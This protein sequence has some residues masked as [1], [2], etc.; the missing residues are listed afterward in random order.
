MGGLVLLGILALVGVLTFIVPRQKTQVAAG[1]TQTAVAQA[2]QVAAQALT[3]SPTTTA[4]ATTM[5]P[6]WTPTP[7]PT[8]TTFPTPTA[9]RVVKDGDT[10]ARVTT[11]PTTTRSAGSPSGTMP[12]AGFGQMG[13]VAVA[14]G[15]VG[16]LLV[17][18]RLRMRN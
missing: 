14:V 8:W 10:A 16:L 4:T 2:T 11:D 17:A 12:D 5:M 13:T 1:H 18:R 7:L 9:T 15:L 6:T 3:P